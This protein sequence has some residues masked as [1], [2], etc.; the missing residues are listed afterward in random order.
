MMTFRERSPDPAGS[1]FRPRV[2]LVSVDL[3]KRDA[4]VRILQESGR[5]GLTGEAASADEAVRLAA[6]IQPDVVVLEVAPD[7]PPI[8]VALRSVLAS[9]PAAKIVIWAPEEVGER[10]LDALRAG[11]AGFVGPQLDSDAL[12]R[13]LAGVAA[14]EAALSRGFTTWVIARIREEPER[15]MGMR[16]VSSELT[17]REWEVL[18]LVSAGI[19]KPAIARDLSVTVGTVRSHLRSLSRKLSLDG[20]EPALGGGSERGCAPTTD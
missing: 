14:G 9:A 4:I 16:P 2:L 1:G 5:F 3:G 12:V 13:T 17:S 18:D 6:S 11:A 8:A 20:P 15:R 19:S 7:G 10:S